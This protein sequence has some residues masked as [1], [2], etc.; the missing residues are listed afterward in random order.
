[1]MRLEVDF[2]KLLDNPDLGYIALGVI[3]I[4]CIYAIAAIVIMLFLKGSK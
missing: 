3:G 4:C 1:M 2:G